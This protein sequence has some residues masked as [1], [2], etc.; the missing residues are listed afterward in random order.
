[1]QCEVF[2][3][4]ECVYP[5]GSVCVICRLANYCRVG[6]SEMS[7][8]RNTGRMYPR[9]SFPLAKATTVRWPGL[10]LR[11]AQQLTA[12]QGE[13]MGITTDPL[14]R[15]RGSLLDELIWSDRLMFT[16]L[17]CP[18]LAIKRKQPGGVSV[19]LGMPWWEMRRRQRRDKQG[20]D[21]EVH[22]PTRYRHRRV[23]VPVPPRART[24][25]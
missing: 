6:R 1:M 20:T 5:H 15:L 7:G 16:G 3:G 8:R 10:R 18:S 9:H 17:C 24:L 23:R 11:R 14:T 25:K 21:A 4:V 12:L 2:K 22:P 19:F 13:D